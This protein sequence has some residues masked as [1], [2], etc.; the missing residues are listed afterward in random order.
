MSKKHQLSRRTFLRGLGAT[1]SLPVLEA[2]LPVAQAAEGAALTAP[3]RMA[4]IF[5]PNGAIVPSW[6]SKGEGSNWEFSRTL[7]PLAAHK[8]QVTVFNGLTQHHGRANGDGAGDHARNAGSFLTGA[9]PVKTAGANIRVDVSVDQAAASLI[10]QQTKLPSLE[11]GTERGRNGGSCDSGYSCAYSSNISWKTESTPMA[12]EINPK[13]AFERLF[14]AAGAQDRAARNRYRKSILDMVAEDAA[15]LSRRLGKT[16]QRKLD[17]Y[18]T[19][20]RELE[21]RIDREA[22]KL[23]EVPDYKVPEGIPTELETHIRLMFD[24]MTLAFQTDTTRISTFMLANAGNNRSY[25]MLGVN[26]G[27][28]SLSHHRNDPEKMEDI[29]K[30]DTFLVS[31]FAYFLDKLKAVKEGDR[32]LLD[33]CLILYGSAIADGNRHTHHDLPIVLAGSGGGQFKTG[34]LRTYPKETP[35]NNLFVSMCHMAGAKVEELGDS[36]G[37]L[38]LGAPTSNVRTF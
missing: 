11:L 33:N 10:G 18:F 21:Q 23:T 12:K 2:M 1:M 7:A 6:K 14:G 20:V 19:S 17:E 8:D 16:D 15:A 26:G 13:L 9:Q 34:Q 32:T 22:T 24:I 3:V 35:L 37:R 36:T 38:N 31:Q 29:T 25:P 28:H 5:F 30:I 27:H 4:F